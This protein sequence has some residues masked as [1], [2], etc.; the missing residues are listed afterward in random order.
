MPFGLANGPATFWRFTNET[1][2]DYLEDFMT[3]FIDD[4]FIYSEKEIE[5]QEHV[6]KVLQRIREAGLQ[7][8]ISF[9]L[10]YILTI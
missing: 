2:M 9:T 4:L 5:H 3:A 7:V 6:R 1:F 8:S 10:G